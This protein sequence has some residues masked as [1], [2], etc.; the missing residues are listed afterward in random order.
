VEPAATV[1]LG[2]ALAVPPLKPFRLEAAEAEAAFLGQVPT[3][4]AVRAA[5]GVLAAEAEAAAIKTLAV[6]VV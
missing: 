5:Q 4:L 3:R 2:A 1:S 6:K